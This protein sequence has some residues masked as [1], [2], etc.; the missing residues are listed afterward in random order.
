MER[1]KEDEN[2][3]GEK[4]EE[5]MRKKWFVMRQPCND[6][7]IMASSFEYWMKERF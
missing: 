2:E 1:K 6:E 7:T 5:G 3:R 4:R